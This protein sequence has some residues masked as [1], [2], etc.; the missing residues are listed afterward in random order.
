VQLSDKL[1]FGA[2]VTG[3]HMTGAHV[4]G[5]H[6]TGAHVTGAHVISLESHRNFS[7]WSFHVFVDTRCLFA[8]LHPWAWSVRERFVWARFIDYFTFFEDYF[9][10]TVSNL[11]VL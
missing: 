11:R 4:N 2:H 5:A 6:A 8:T 1:C 9:V 7:Y 3:P 10:Y